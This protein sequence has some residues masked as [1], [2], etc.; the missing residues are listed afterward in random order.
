MGVS[1][2]NEIIRELL[3]H[4]DVRNSSHSK[5]YRNNTPR[6]MFQKHTW[7]IYVDARVFIAQLVIFVLIWC[8]RARSFDVILLS[9]F[10][11]FVQMNN[12]LRKRG[13]S[14]WGSYNI[15]L[16]NA[17][18]KLMC[19][20]VLIDPVIAFVKVVQYSDRGEREYLINSLP[21]IVCMGSIV[22]SLSG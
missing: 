9:W 18:E 6:I 2:G 8:R 21:F 17:I 16:G 19:L 12:S 10:E 7:L 3:C 4:Y 1:P 13:T 14:L 20:W 22:E 11:I 15:G 5:G